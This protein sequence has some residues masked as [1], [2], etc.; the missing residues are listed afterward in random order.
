MFNQETITGVI[1]RNP[2]AN[3]LIEP[4]SGTQS[5]GL[6][7]PAGYQRAIRLGGLYTQIISPYMIFYIAL[8]ILLGVANDG[9][10]GVAQTLEA[11][12]K[13]PLAFSTNVLL[14]GLF[15]VLFFGTVATLFAALRWRWPVWSSLLLVAGAWQMCAGFGKGLIAHYTFPTLG[16]AYVTGDAA[17][18]AILIP[19]ATSADGLNQGLQQMDSIGVALVWVLMALLPA[20]SGLPRPVRWLSWL[21]TMALLGP[22]PGFLLVI[23]LSP[24]WLFLLGRWLKRQ[25]AAALAVS[26]M[27]CTISG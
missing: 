23:L 14:D 8:L 15:H 5:N 18:K 6:A 19:V 2:A 17:L 13:S 21:L 3:L 11:A 27:D 9:T 4:A 20:A 26:P 10:G 1:N 24:V 7:I 22:D 25:V 16:A 12:G